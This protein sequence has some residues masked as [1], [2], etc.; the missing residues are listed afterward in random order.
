MFLHLF[1]EGEILPALRTAIFP[2]PHRIL[3]GRRWKQR[4]SEVPFSGEGEQKMG[5]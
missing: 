3:L 2:V 5:A 4:E 1:W